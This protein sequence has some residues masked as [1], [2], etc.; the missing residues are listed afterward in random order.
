MAALIV[1]IVVAL[2]I[3]VANGGALGRS[4]RTE[5]PRADAAMPYLT[6]ALKASESL[7]FHMG[8][9]EALWETGKALEAL[10]RDEEALKVLY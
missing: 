1:T 9:G 5:Y 2:A 10:G 4:W 6:K 8:V 3:S 7:G